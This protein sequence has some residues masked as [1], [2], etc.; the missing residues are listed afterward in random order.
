MSQIC[1][2]LLPGT[3]ADP[4]ILLHK[5]FYYYCFSK[6]G[7]SL[8]VAKASRLCDIAAAEPVCVYKAP[9]GTPYSKD[10]WAPELHY[11]EGLWVI[12]VAADDGQ[13]AQHRMYALT[14]DQPQGSFRM[15]GKVSSPDDHWAIDGTAFSFRD[16]LYFVW[17]G[18]EGNVD[19]S[20]QLYI[21]PMADPF[22]ICGERICLSRPEHV[23]E[24][25]GHP[26]VNEGPEALI[27][28]GVL[29][30]VYSASGSWTDDYCLG[31]LT[32]MEDDPLQPSHWQKSENPVFSKKE[33]AYGPG[34]CSF[35]TN[36]SGTEDWIVYHANEISGSGWNGRSVRAQQFTW[37]DNTPVFGTPVPVG[38]TL[39]MDD[40]EG[41]I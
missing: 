11:L 30:L 36:P 24:T 14:A 39:F 19:V 17:S 26:L 34:H 35:T 23:W 28:N 25:Q 9:E 7:N 33:S 13:N 27:K 15:V 1:T 21:A 37:Q 38:T 20:Q 22:T 29:H 3:H 41:L 18:W 32:L 2:P 16:R 31:L 40:G 10:Y 5:G 8:W 6:G 4:W 12:Y